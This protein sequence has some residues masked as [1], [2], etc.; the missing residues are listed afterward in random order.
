M[1]LRARALRQR[2]GARGRRGP[3]GRGRLEPRR[4]RGRRPAPPRRGLGPLPG[5]PLPGRPGSG[6]RRAPARRHDRPRDCGRSLRAFRSG[7]ARASGPSAWP[8]HPR[9][10]LL[11]RPTGRHRGCRGGR[12]P[13]LWAGRGRS[14]ALPRAG[15]PRPQ[16]APG[17]R[18][19]RPRRLSRPARRRSG[20]PARARAVAPGDPH[21]ARARA[22]LAGA[23]GRRPRER[24][25]RARLRRRS[26]LCGRAHRRPLPRARP[27]RP[28]ERRP[29]TPHDDLLRRLRTRSRYRPP[30]RPPPFGRALDPSAPRAPARR[31]RLSEARLLS[32]PANELTLQTAIASRSDLFKYGLLAFASRENRNR[33]ALRLP[34][35][36]REFA[37]L[38]RRGERLEL[39]QRLVLDL[40]DPLAGDVEGAADLVERARMLAAEPVAEL[41]H[42]A[43]AVGEV[44]EGLLERLLGEQLGGALE[45]G[46]GAL[47]GD[48]LAELRLLLVAD[49]LLEGDGRL[50]RALDRVDLLGL[51]V[52]GDLGDLLRRRLAAELGDQL[53]LRAA[54]LVELLDD[55]DRDADGPRLVG[56]RSGDRLADPPGG[57]GGELEAPAVVELLRRTD[58]AQRPLL[59]QVEEG[60]ALVAVVLG[61]RDDESKV[62]LDHLLLGVE[63]AAL[64]LLRE[65]DLL[66]GGEQPDFAD[67]L[68]EELQ[69]V[70]GHVRLQVERRLL[71]LATALA[72]GPLVLGGGLLSRV[73]VLDQ[74]DTRLLEVP[75]EVLDV[76]LVELDLGN[77]RG[78]VTEG[79]HAK[80]LTAGDQRPY[81]LKLL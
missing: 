34:D 20:G 3:P 27:G 46:L 55:V 23:G 74:L 19:A 33:S 16:H 15:P 31:S 64:D 47:I 62:R 56:E 75:V 61:D 12:H 39:L 66:G 69:G 9:L 21:F 4:R 63:L 41:E 30:A 42:A 78:D 57:V 76:G 5:Q 77:G 73:E 44:L 29:A 38:L 1:P 68:E 14:R 60:Q 40:A 80:L 17:R 58:Q 26:G 7:R 70:G 65:V 51:D 6:G 11:P 28:T 13:G 48:E 50:G 67:V 18:F 36:L 71:A 49:R 53:A 59:D 35:Q 43:L 79:E 24:A 52:A 10:L 2:L 45:G 22:R 32:P 25:R 8:R 37:K 54:D 72:I 81:F